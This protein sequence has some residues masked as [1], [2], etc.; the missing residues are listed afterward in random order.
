MG[1][2]MYVFRASRPRFN[3]NAVYARSKIDGIILPEEKANEPMYRQ[4]LPFCQKLKIR[5]KYY[6]MDR[7]CRDNGLTRDE[8]Y[9]SMISAA[10]T[11]FADLSV[12]PSRVVS[13]S[14]QVIEER[15]VLEKVEPCFVCTLDEVRYWRKAYDIEDWFCEHFDEKVEN[16][17]YYRIS[18][19]MLRQFN[20]A[21][22]EY[23]IDEPA[24]T[25]EGSIFYHEWY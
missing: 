2:D 8:T 16:T 14:S 19:D 3:E 22:P 5:N 7:I 23:V 11:S 12:T 9:V 17:G 10:T 1:L 15:Y 18:D 13:I 6:D 20:R 21:W 4:L 25:E 24:D